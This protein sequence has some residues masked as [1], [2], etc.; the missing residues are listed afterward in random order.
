VNVACFQA[1]VSASGR[2]L[3][4]R[5]PI[6]CGVSDCDREAS[7]MKRPGPLGAVEPWRRNNQKSYLNVRYIY[8]YIYIYI[9]IYI[10]IYAYRAFHNVIRD[11]KNLL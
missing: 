9:C 10:Y 1:E 8:M 4:Q 11:Y 7:T 6:E 2:S 5:S 3:V